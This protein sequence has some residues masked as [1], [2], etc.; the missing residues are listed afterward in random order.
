VAAAKTPT[1]LTLTWPR[2]ANNSAVIVGYA[3]TLAVDSGMVYRT[4]HPAVAEPAGGPAV[5]QRVFTD[6]T[7][8]GRYWATVQVGCGSRRLRPR[9]N[10]RSP[11]AHQPHH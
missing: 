6:L 9:L 2:P 4:S 1:T 10:E 11:G 5:V 8:L 3:L 7:P